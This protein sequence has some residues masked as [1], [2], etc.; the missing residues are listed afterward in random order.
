MLQMSRSRNDSLH[1]QWETIAYEV[2]VLTWFDFIKLD[3]IPIFLS[4]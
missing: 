4:N 1:S 3:D 2:K